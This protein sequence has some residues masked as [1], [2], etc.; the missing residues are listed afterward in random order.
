MSRRATSFGTE[1]SS[2]VSSKRRSQPPRDSQPASSA[3][4][5]HTLRQRQPPDIVPFFVDGAAEGDIVRFTTDAECVRWVVKRVEWS[6][7][8]TILVLPVRQGPKAFAEGQ[9]QGVHDV[10]AA[11]GLGAEAY[12]VEFP[13]VALSV[14]PDADLPAVKPLLN[15]GKEAGWWAYDEA[16]VESVRCSPSTRL[17]STS[18]VHAGP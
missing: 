17:T 8:C 10:F 14:P 9:R 15:R 2:A 12:S 18:I 3:H 11:L 7:R 1:P 6:G 13:L 4:D 16:C 5:D